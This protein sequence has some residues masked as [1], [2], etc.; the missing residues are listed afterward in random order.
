MVK[1][2]P[3]SY[4]PTLIEGVACAVLFATMLPACTPAAESAATAKSAAIGTGKGLFLLDFNYETG[5]VTDVHV[6][7]STGS[8]KLDAASIRAFKLWRCK[9]RTY[10]HIK[11]P[12]T[13]TLQ[14]TQ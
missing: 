11:V 4:M 5:R 8:A 3:I 14:K 9:P 10:T 7:Q 1:I 2:T 12:M 6:L 13:Y